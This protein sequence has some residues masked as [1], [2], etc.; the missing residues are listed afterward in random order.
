MLRSLLQVDLTMKQVTVVTV[1]AR[2]MSVFL[3]DNS[4]IEN[5]LIHYPCKIN[6]IR[7]FYDL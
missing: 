1:R 7:Y 6:M 2:N 5:K 4:R 3:L